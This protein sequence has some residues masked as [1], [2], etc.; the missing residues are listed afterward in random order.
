MSETPP[1]A[2][3]LD[4]ARKL[5]TELPGPETAARDAAAERQANLV[6]PVGSLGRLEELAVWLAAW[7]G[8]PTP[9]LERPRI[10]VYAGN[11]GVAA[12]GVSAYPAEVTQ[13][14]VATFIGGG[15]AI[16]QLAEL[17]GADLRIY[18][19]ALDQPT[20]DFTEGPAMEEEDCAR[21][22]AY[23]IMSVEEGFDVM[24]LGEMGIANTTAAAALCHGLFGGTAAD[25]V[26][27]GTGVD[28][29]GLERKRAAV[30]QARAAN[31]PALDDP[32]ETLRCLGGL[33][34]AAIAGAVL[35]CRMARI[36]VVLDGYACTAAAAALF[37]A[38]ARALDHC[39]V[40][41]R[42]VEPG[43]AR[44]LEILDKRP[45]L[46]LD[47]RLGEASGAALGLG[48][49]KAAVACHAGM[50]T[51]ADAGISAR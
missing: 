7:Q 46:D 26:G 2:P 20:A 27:R 5:L 31:R 36:P 16:N 21:A 51:F 14:M 4:D 22:L 1:E 32:L 24:A 40:A 29:A 38:D 3:S 48:V 45:L 41:H 13:L 47:L 25:W 23:G 8:H 39:V 49:L 9:R 12:R 17:A 44:L 33:E 42:S 6:K 15:G 10:A 34:L 35:A 30:E 28:D 37:A 50:S 11:H 19:L 18:E 43:H